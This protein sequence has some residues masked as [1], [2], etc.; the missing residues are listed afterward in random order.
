ML[1]NSFV[2]GGF[3]IADSPPSTDP[4]PIRAI[5]SATP[6]KNCFI[7]S[8]HLH[9]LFFVFAAPSTVNQNL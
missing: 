3:T 5:A 7:L 4:H 2:D 6:T 1:L 9:L 8:F